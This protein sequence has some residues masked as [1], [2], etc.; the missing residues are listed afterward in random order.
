[1]IREDGTPAAPPPGRVVAVG[2]G[3]GPA[4]LSKFIVSSFKMSVLDKARLESQGGGGGLGTVKR[5][6]TF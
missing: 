5:F 6:V 4:I 2:I 1:M 3:N